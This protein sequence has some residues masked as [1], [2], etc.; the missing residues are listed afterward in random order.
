M[1]QVVDIISEE[2]RKLPNPVRYTMWNFEALAFLIFCMA[3]STNW[4]GPVDAPSLQVLEINVR[5]TTSEECEEPMR[6][7]ARAG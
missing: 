7:Q 6:R 5:A 1:S 4:C 2:V 3:N